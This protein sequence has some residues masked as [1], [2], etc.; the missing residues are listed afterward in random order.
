MNKRAVLNNIK[1]RWD[2]PSK[3]LEFL[4]EMD[5]QQEK[6]IED[7]YKKG[8]K[9]TTKN[10]SILFAYSLRKGGAGPKT[11][12]LYLENINIVANQL[13]KGELTLEDMQKE[14]QKAGINIS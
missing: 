6:D 1:K 9:E 12:P 8:L 5:K 10:Y 2:N 14:L 11:L 7:A 4:V 13:E 3:L